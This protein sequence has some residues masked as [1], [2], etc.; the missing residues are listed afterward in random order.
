MAPGTP[1]VREVWQIAVICRDQEGKGAD[2]QSFYQ[3]KATFQCKPCTATGRLVQ[4]LQILLCMS[5]ASGRRRSATVPSRSI[6]D[7]NQ[8]AKLIPPRLGQL[9]LLWPGT[10]ALRLRPGSLQWRQLNL[11]CS[12][13][14]GWP[15]KFA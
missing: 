2:E 13:I 7:G 3:A 4:I 9:C 15:A 11:P 6:L 8:R 1:G 10:A 14:P 12:S 5:R